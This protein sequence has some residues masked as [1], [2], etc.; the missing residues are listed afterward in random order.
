MKITDVVSSVKTRW[1]P[2]FANALMAMNW[3]QMGTRAELLVKLHF[4]KFCSTSGPGKI[5]RVILPLNQYF[6][7]CAGI[8]YRTL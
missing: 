2:S 8:S 7:P 5:M 1:V 3:T 4:A 6:T